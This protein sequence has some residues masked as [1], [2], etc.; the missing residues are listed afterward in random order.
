MIP[1]NNIRFLRT[2]WIL[3]LLGIGGPACDAIAF[4]QDDTLL[5]ATDSTEIYGASEGDAF[6]LPDTSTI[7]IRHFDKQA[8]EKLR[9]DPALNYAEVPMVAESLWDRFVLWLR[10]L[11]QTI[12]EGAV[13]TDWGRVSLFVLGA[14]LLIVVIMMILRVNAFKV[15]FFSRGATSFK[16]DVLDE[17]IHEMDF[18]RLIQE[19][20]LKKDYR[21][22]VRLTFLYALKMLSDRNLIRWDQ[23]KTNHDYLN[24]LVSQELRSGFHELNYYFEY[25]W[26]GN[27]GISPEM[28]SSVQEIFNA[29]TKKLR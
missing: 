21:V 3:L 29:W 15:F 4:P 20:T 2:V 6:A 22:G 1:K 25:A 17:N 19:A 8:L 14:V 12:F 10:Q 5:L 7:T 23:G 13:S 18:E 16:H 26:Y 9:T 28:F 27:F 24:E 11:M